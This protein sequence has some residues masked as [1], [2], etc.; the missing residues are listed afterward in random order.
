MEK[1][2]HIKAE[3]EIYSVFQLVSESK[4]VKVLT[5][6]RENFIRLEN[7]RRSG[8]KLVVKICVHNPE[9]PFKNA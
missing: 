4:A 5:N 8:C 3:S 1:L 7:R 9:L 2:I 6:I